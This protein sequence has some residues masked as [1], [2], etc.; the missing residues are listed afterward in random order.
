MKLDDTSHIVIQ[1]FFLYQCLDPLHGC[2]CSLQAGKGTQAKAQPCHSHHLYVGFFTLLLRFRI[3]LPGMQTWAIYFIQT[4]HLY[5]SDLTVPQAGTASLK[6]HLT[7]N[8]PCQHALSL[9]HSVIT[10]KRHLVAVS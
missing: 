5:F 3:S 4:M 1:H 8:C 6:F 7:H 2:D 10:G 9:A